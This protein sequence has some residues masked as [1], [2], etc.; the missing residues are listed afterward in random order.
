MTIVG[1]KK[2]KNMVIFSGNNKG[3]NNKACYWFTECCICCCSCFS[4]VSR[5]QGDPVLYYTHALLRSFSPF[6]IRLRTY[7]SSLLNYDSFLRLTSLLRLIFSP[8]HFLRPTAQDSLLKIP[9]P[10]FTSIPKTYFLGL[11][12]YVSHFSLPLITSH[13]L[14]LVS[15]LHKTNFLR[16]TLSLLKTNYLRLT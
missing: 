12:F 2:K 1:K 4:C 8:I 16:L 15:P 10:R 14:R 6:K 7:S 13:F 3:E 11:V 9:F 5:W